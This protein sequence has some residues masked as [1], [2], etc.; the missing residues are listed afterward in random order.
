MADTLQPRRSDPQ[1]I[2]QQLIGVLN[3]VLQASTTIAIVAAAQI[4]DSFF[5]ANGD[6][7]S[8]GKGSPKDFLIELWRLL[9][10]VA[11]QIPPRDFKLDRL[12]ELVAQLSRLPSSKTVKLLAVETK[13]W[14]ELPLLGSSLM[15]EWRCPNLAIDIT[16][17]G[18]GQAERRERY[19]RLNALIIRLTRDGTLDLRSYGLATLRDALEGQLAPARYSGVKENPFPDAALRCRVAA[20][21]EWIEQCGGIIFDSDENAS[22]VP[23]GPLW[24]GTKGFSRG[25]WD[26]WKKRFGLISEHDRAKEETKSAARGARDRMTEIEKDP[27]NGTRDDIFSGRGNFYVNF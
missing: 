16:K 20:A 22:D 27:G 25:R 17:V 11:E 8:E 2:E 1:E 4:L 14:A 9:F 5:P 3:I 21:A 18:A 19:L 10:K 26:L 6:E 24:N 12:A 7:P 15:N 23:G 13:V